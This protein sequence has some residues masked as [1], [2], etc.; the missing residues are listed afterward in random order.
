MY[1]DALDWMRTE[2][3]VD[4]THEG[5]RR[6]AVPGK[7]AEVKNCACSNPAYAEGLGSRKCSESGNLG[8]DARFLGDEQ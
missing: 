4:L 5:G 8:D 6:M 7:K 2:F 1:A 3:L